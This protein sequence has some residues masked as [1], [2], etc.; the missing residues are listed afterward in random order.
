MNIVLNNA[1]NIDSLG[2]LREDYVADRNLQ[3]VMFEL[4][5]SK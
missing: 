5:S 2:N 1:L 4:D 3:E